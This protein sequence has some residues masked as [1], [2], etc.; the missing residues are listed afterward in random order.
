MNIIRIAVLASGFLVGGVGC[1]TMGTLQTAQ[2]TGEGNF[3]LA[4]EPSLVAYTSTDGGGAGLGYLNI[5]GR[6]GVSDRVDI[7]AR[8]GSSGAELMAKF[9]LTDPAKRDGVRIAVAPSGGG[10]FIGGGGGAAGTFA[11]QIPVIFDIPVGGGSALVLAP[12]LHDWI[13]AAGTGDGGGVAS[14]LSLGASVGFS[15]RLGPKFRLLPEVA[16]LMPF[17]GAAGS[18]GSGTTSAGLDVGVVGLQFSVGLLFG[19]RPTDE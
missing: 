6:Y 8:V 10:F 7:G 13:V 2:T 5:S 17:A 16:A 3:E 14:I 9:S 12:K 18:N 4:V 15:A 1:A 19:G 11:F